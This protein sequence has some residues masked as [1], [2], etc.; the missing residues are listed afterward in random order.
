MPDMIIPA[1]LPGDNY[2]AL[3]N[4]GIIPDP[5]YEKNEEIVQK[6]RKYKWSFKR[7]FEVSAEMLAKKYI[8]LEVSMADTFIDCRINGKKVFSGKNAFTAYRPEIRKLLKEGI[9]NIEFIFYPVEDICIYLIFIKLIVYPPYFENTE[10]ASVYAL[11]FLY[12]TI[13]LI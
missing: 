9:N 3:F 5:Y 2:S 12:F 1:Q 7:D 10:Y 13:I 11:L 6:Y 4:A 8:Y